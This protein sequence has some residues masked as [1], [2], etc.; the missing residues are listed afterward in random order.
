MIINSDGAI[1]LYHGTDWESALDILNHGIDITKLR[2]LQQAVTQLGEGFYTTND[3]DTAW[4]FAST[5]PGSIDKNYTVIEI[6]LLVE[7]LESLFEQSLAIR[8]SI[9]NVQFQGEQI[10]F[11]PDAFDFMNE[12]ALF[13]PFSGGM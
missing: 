4:Y 5:A 2:Y 1:I 13:R 7:H 6:E 10:W 11:H 8:H 12:N 9:I 3:I